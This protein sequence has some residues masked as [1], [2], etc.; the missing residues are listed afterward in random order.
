MKI[1]I[2]KLGEIFFFTKTGRTGRTNYISGYLLI[3]TIQCAI[4]ASIF[5]L[6]SRYSTIL[7]SGIYF[8]FIPLFALILLFC[9]LFLGYLNAKRQHDLGIPS[10]PIMLSVRKFIQKGQKGTNQYGKE[11]SCEPFFDE[12]SGFITYYQEH[13]IY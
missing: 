12:L 13:I 11:P 7:F 3:R 8:L 4:I 2:D 10:W 1:S 9:E 6:F 5:V